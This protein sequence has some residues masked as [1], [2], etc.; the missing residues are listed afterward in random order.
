MPCPKSW[1]D[2]A[3]YCSP[4]FTAPAGQQSACIPA[5]GAWDIMLRFLTSTGE[6]LRQYRQLRSTSRGLE[7]RHLLTGLTAEQLDGALQ[8]RFLV[9]RLLTD[10]QE[11]LA[12]VPGMQEVGLLL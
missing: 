7:T 9:L 11:P 8:G 10:Q 5:T 12:W 3:G 2:R 1:G 6:L 4:F